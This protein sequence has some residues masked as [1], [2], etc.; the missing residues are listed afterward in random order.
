VFLH[1]FLTFFS[2]FLLN[3]FHNSYRYS[4]FLIQ[5]CFTL[6]IFIA[7]QVIKIIFDLIAILF[8][9][10]FTEIRIQPVDLNKLKLRTFCW[11]GKD[12][13]SYYSFPFFDF[14]DRELQVLNRSKGFHFLHKTVLTV[15][16]SLLDSNRL[17]LLS[18]CPISFSYM[19]LELHEIKFILA[20]SMDDLDL[21]SH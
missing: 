12:Y 1:Y 13:S 9:N 21:V 20:Y 10:L 4:I 14:P 7:H 8:R 5:L 18:Q 6:D 3:V 19:D 11:N 16:N 17:L 2:I 15:R